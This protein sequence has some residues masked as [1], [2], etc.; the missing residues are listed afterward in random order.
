MIHYVTGDLLQSDAEAL[1]NT[2]NTVGVMG[3]GIALQ[4]KEQFPE[5]FKIYK[6][7]CKNGKLDIGNLLITEASSLL[8][9]RKLIINFPTKK[10]WKYPSEYD[11]IEQGLN[12]LA[13]DIKSLNIKSIAIPPLGSHNGGLE[14]HRVKEMIVN[15]LQSS[16]CDIFIYEPSVEIV[17]KM[18]S[19]R[20]PLTA[21]R[22]ML[23]L[24][25]A[26]MRRYGEF[27]SVFAAEKLV[28]F[29]QR[30][31]A[32]N[33]FNIKFIPYYYGPYSQG[34]ISH[35]LYHLNGSY[36]KGMHALNLKPFDNIWLMPYAD[37]EAVKFLNA[38]NT[39]DIQQILNRTKSLLK[40][41]YSDH[42]L[43]LLASVDYLL[44]NAPAL[45]NWQSMPTDEVA[46]IL[47]VE[48]QNWNSRK[49][50]IFKP[51]FIAKAF[52]HLKSNQSLLC[53]HQ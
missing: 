5:N 4:F 47:S 52:E 22:A 9:G 34:K 39:N 37:E 29:M 27:A 24:M 23:I 50:R 2:V 30:C 8:S 51:A 31:G 53:T 18:K 25:F 21:A 15:K 12:A 19:E 14:W 46:A 49:A 40:E 35:V 20:V 26:E 36:I 42:A 33:I 17:E 32:Q 41:F 43:E 7:A 16:E 38:Q 45:K 6:E 11:Y 10:H 3:K 1:V 13:H 48:I 44:E 28:Y